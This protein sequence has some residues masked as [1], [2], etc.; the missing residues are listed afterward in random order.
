[1][2]LKRTLFRIGVALGV[3]VILAV[4]AGFFIL[5]SRAFHR[6]VLATIVAKT[7]QGA[8]SQVRIGDFAFQL[9]GLRLDLYRV[10]LYGSGPRNTPPLLTAD[11]LVLGLRLVSILHRK[12][13]LSSLRVDH[14]VVHMAISKQGQTNLPRPSK[15]NKPGAALNVFSLA[16]R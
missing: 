10:A 9:S 3:V 5:R 15:S 2:T 11:R 14:P 16:V 12:I 8:G 1:M 6:Y 7:S 13:G 4:V